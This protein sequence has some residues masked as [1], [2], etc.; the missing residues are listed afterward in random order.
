MLS[1][2]YADQVIVDD[3]VMVLRNDELMTARVMNVSSFTMQ[4]NYSSTFSVV[5]LK[6]VAEIVL[7]S[8]FVL[9]LSDQFS[10]PLP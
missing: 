2:R 8:S 1:Y 10:T 4:G 6:H 7:N 9:N 3:E 5:F